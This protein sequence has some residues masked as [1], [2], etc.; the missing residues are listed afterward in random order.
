[1]DSFHCSSLMREVS[2]ISAHFLM[3]KIMLVQPRGQRIL[4]MPRSSLRVHVTVGDAITSHAMHR[5]FE[6][7]EETERKNRRLIPLHRLRQR[8]FLNDCLMYRQNFSLRSYEAGMEKNMV[9]GTI[10]SFLR[11]SARNQLCQML[12]FE[13]L[14]FNLQ[15]APSERDNASPGSEVLAVQNFSVA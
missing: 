4:K 3:S 2:V 14:E 7:F 13:C 9:I 6:S 12:N 11:V 8:G 10:F 5:K 15:V 1:M